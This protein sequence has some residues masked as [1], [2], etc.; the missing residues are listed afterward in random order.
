M[1]T[2]ASATEINDLL[3]FCSNARYWLPNRSA[4]F[5]KAKQTRNCRAN[6][7]R[8]KIYFDYAER[9]RQSRKIENFAEIAQLVEHNLAKVGVVS[10][11]LVFRS[12]EFFDS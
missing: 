5:R 1:P 10:P 12:K 11:S 4:L 8:S 2:F 9:R 7:S 6:E 3:K